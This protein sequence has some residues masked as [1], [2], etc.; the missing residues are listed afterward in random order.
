[1]NICLLTLE[2]PNYGGGIGTYMFNLA[3][4]L[5]ELKHEVT[6]ITHNQNPVRFNGINIIE[7]PLP[8]IENTIK[9]KIMR[10]RWQPHH[11]WSKQ[12]WAHFL[13]LN[14]TFD[15]IETAEYGSW[16][17]Y[18]IGNLNTPIVVRCHTPAKGV[19]EISVNGDKHKTPF[20]L[21][22]EDK[23]ERFHT[24]NA[25][26]ISTPSHVLANHISLNWSIPIS[27][28]KVLPNPV[29][30]EFFKPSKITEK[31][32]EIL[33]V[34][35]L[36]YNKGV[37]DLIEAVKPLLK[38]HPDLNIR[39][40]GKDLKNPKCIKSS[41]EMVSEELYARIA[42]ENHR[43]LNLMGW[44][45]L[46][47]LLSYQ[48]KALCAVVP[49]RGF[50]SFSYTLTEHMACGSAVVATHCGGPTEIINDEE[51]GLLVPP[52]DIEALR[53]ALRRLIINADLCREMGNRARKKI[54]DKYS[55]TKV[56]PKITDWYAQTI[57]NYQNGKL[58]N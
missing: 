50:E 27:R 44:V 20:W 51:D 3:Q 43:Q 57:E 13:N 9:K 33:Y 40:I 15:I 16:A 37:F 35:R 58:Y 42:P 24:R 2:W 19:R 52:G 39:F 36:Q 26:A 31:K 53:D 30:I 23:R 49:S 38:E 55:I 46:D 47:E 4:G 25:N 29:D 10:W 32:K 18:F 54:E 22:L 5:S 12:A 28:I 41:F 48:Q 45:T 34:G 21:Q 11:S 56:V 14:T 17:R 1:M 8:Q 7:V 6:V